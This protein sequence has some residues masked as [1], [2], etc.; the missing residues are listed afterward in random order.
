MP[1]IVL[2]EGVSDANAVTAL[3]TRTVGDLSTLGVRVVALGGATN[4]RSVVGRIATISARP[5]VL[6]LCDEGETRYFARAFASAGIPASGLFVCCSDLED[7]LIRAIG[8]PAVVDFV[9]GQGELA[10]FRIMQQ[11]PA[12][13]HRPLDRQLHRFIGA[14]SGRKKRY[15]RQLV[16]WL[17]LERIPEPLAHLLAAL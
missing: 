15:G 12:Q 9:A 8:P 4:A 2:V 7:E 10:G 13:R 16:D 1:T 6:G 11:Q 14:R 17:D 5:R 3:A